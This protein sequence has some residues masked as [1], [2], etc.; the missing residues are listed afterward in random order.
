MAALRSSWVMTSASRPSCTSSSRSNV[1]W[2]A[3]GAGEHPAP[4][5]RSRQRAAPMSR[6]F[7]RLI[8]SPVLPTDTAGRCTGRRP[9]CSPLSG[10]EP[11]WRVSPLPGQGQDLLLALHHIDESHR[12]RQDQGRGHRSGTDQLGH[13]DQRGGGVAH[14]I[15]PLGPEGRP[16]VHRCRR[17]G[18]PGLCRPAGHLR[19][20]H[21]AVDADAQPLQRPRL[22]PDRAMLVSVRMGVPARRL[23]PRPPPPRG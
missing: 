2:S 16:L 12:H 18:G 1:S 15:D 10:P 22:M 17:P 5:S 20:R 7:P 13:A 21:E 3:P 23:G 19:V 9:P 4:K 11:R 6:S 14:G 8:I